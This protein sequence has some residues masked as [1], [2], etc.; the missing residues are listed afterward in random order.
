MNFDTLNDGDMFTVK[1]FFDQEIYK[2]KIVLVKR[3]I[4]K[5]KFGKVKTLVFK[6]LVLEGRVFKDKE[7]VTLWI[8]D[9]KNKIPIKIKASVIV[10]VLKAELIEYKGLTNSFPIIFN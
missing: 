1:T 5:T 8:T 3:D 4:I 7:T 9:D 10:G 6:P 2:I